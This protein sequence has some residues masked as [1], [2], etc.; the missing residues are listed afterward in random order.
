MSTFTH[1]DPSDQYFSYSKPAHRFQF[2][3]LCNLHKNTVKEKDILYLESADGS[4][5]MELLRLGFD[6][7]QLHPCNH[8]K[9]DPNATKILQ[10]KFPDAVVECGD[11]HNVYK[12]QKWLGVW[13]DMELTWNVKNRNSWEW[14]FDLIPDFNQATVVIVT[15]SSG[16]MPGGAESLATELSQLLYKKGG[17]LPALCTA[18][19]GR[20][21]YMNMVYG[22][23]IFNVEMTPKSLFTELYLKILHIPVAE[24]AHLSAQEWPDKE[25]YMVIN[26]CY[27]AIVTKFH[28]RM[29]QIHYL[30]VDN[31]YFM[32]YEKV[33]FEQ[34]KKWW[35]ANSPVT[36]SYASSSSCFQSS[37][38]CFQSSSSSSS[39]S[40]RIRTNV[41][42][43][44][45]KKKGPGYPPKV[46][47]YCNACE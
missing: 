3:Y 27:H 17:Y 44:C 12:K 40:K 34:V 30:N 46:Q 6:E 33:T 10:A 42:P 37:S 19:K 15:L 22:V 1:H 7:W 18:Y 36:T 2:A 38:S 8:N 47:W 23:A 24:F 11:I 41:C 31:N 29:F 25:N 5:T 13:F 16:H 4:A 35:S 14:N 20:G 45:N 43:G 9:H 21:G 26:N 39:S 28:M 32:E